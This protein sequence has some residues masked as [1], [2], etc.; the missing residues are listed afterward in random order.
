MGYVA[1]GDPVLQGII[2]SFGG[3]LAG[4]IAFAAVFAMRRRPSRAFGVRRAGRNRLFLGAGFAITSFISSLLIIIAYRSVAGHTEQPQAI[5][6]AAAQ[7]GVLPF[8]ISLIGG[9]VLTP[10]GEELL[11]R[12]VVANALNKYGSW[13]GV[14]LSSIIFGLVHGWSEVFWV[15]VVV[16]FLAASIFR[17]TRSIWPCVVLHSLHNALHSFTSAFGHSLA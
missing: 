4:I 7:A 9:A 16:G 11:F 5:L 10:I 6:H 15:A 17:R 14:G 2:G 13:V 3:G 1:H 12:G 8:T